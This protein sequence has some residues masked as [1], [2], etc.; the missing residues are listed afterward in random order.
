LCPYGDGDQVSWSPEVQCQHAF[1]TNCIIP[2][3]AKQE[4]PKCPVC[5]QEFCPPALVEP[6]IVE[7]NRENALLES[8]SQAL[9]SQFYRFHSLESGILATNAIS[10]QLAIQNRTANAA[11]ESGQ[12]NAEDTES[13]VG[14][15]G[16]W[17]S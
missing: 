14:S 2:W 17:R 15:R 13:S 16:R 1:H 6:G 12:H 5:R 3:L 9:S 10:I 8:F 4:E 11:V 7:L